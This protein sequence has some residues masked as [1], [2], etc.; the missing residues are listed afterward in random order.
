MVP[1]VV[2]LLTRRSSAPG[3]HSGSSS[4]PTVV[5]PVVLVRGAGVQAETT[6][7]GIDTAAV[8]TGAATGTSVAAGTAVGTPTS[9]GA[10]VATGGMS[11][12]VSAGEGSERQR[13]SRRS[14]P[15]PRP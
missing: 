12:G 15:A 7:T 4:P 3:V 6:T 2:L 13:A 11:V 5:Q 1:A 14:G 8:S 9:V 10:G